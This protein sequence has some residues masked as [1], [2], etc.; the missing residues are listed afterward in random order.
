MRML[1]VVQGTANSVVVAYLVLVKTTSVHLDLLTMDRVEM[2]PKKGELG[3]ASVFSSADGLVP[4]FS[5]F[6]IAVD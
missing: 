1:L 3:V 4:I 2:L 6:P 5:D